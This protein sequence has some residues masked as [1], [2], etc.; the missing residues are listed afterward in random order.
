MRTSKKAALL[1]FSLLFAAPLGARAETRVTVDLGGIAFGFEDG[2]WD[3]D[4]RWHDW[5]R[6]GDW[7]RYRSEYREHAYAWRHDRD[8]DMG[9]HDPYWRHDNGRHEGRKHQDHDDHDRD[10][11]GH[12]RHDHD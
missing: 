9:W 2:Y 4:H 1:A 7:E 3:R 5:E 12:A 10:D 6:R 11:R 8:R